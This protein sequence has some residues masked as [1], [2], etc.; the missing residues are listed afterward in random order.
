MNPVFSGLLKIE[1][2]HQSGN[3]HKCYFLPVVHFMDAMM[4]FHF[5]EIRYNAFC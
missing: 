5:P 3:P 4:D 2:F 1:Q